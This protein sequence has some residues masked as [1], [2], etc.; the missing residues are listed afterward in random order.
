MLLDIENTG[1]IVTPEI[2]VNRIHWLFNLEEDFE[3]VSNKL[4]KFNP[5]DILGI[6]HHEYRHSNIIAWLLNPNES[7]NLGDVF[8]KKILFHTMLSEENS[9][10]TAEFSID[11]IAN[12]SF[13]DVEVMREEKD[14]DI[15]VV[16]RSNK[17]IVIIENKINSKEHS[18]QLQRYKT[19]F[20]EDFVDYAHL[21]VFLTLSGEAPS[22]DSYF[23]LTHYTILKTLESILKVKGEVIPENI[24]T[25][26][27]YYAEAIKELSMSDDQLVALCRNIYSKYKKEIDYIYNIG[28]LIDISIALD[29]FK[30][31]FA[32]ANVYWFNQK[33][34]WFNTADLK[35]GGQSAGN[36]GDGFP[37]SYW[38][39]N[40]YNTSLKLV[41]EI[42]PFENTSQRPSFMEALEMNN[43]GFRASAKSPSSVYTRIWTKT[44]KIKD[45]FDRDEI[46]GAMIKLYENKNLKEIHGKLAATIQDFVFE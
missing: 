9:E 23:I 44:I 45:W 27:L 5:F 31:E 35:T 17:V 32:D 41:L 46:L 3:V 33:S 16:S 22:D 40:Y 42:G 15:V 37:Y 30:K 38:F 19:A 18:N 13:E 24:K 28:N 11:L 4:S 10:R 20:K 25:F 39:E 34:I 1:G 2:D 12:V 29:D 26:L 7:H 8:L 21:H 6:T 36:W 43:V 14:A